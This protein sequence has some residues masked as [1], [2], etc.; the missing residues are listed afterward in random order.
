MVRPIPF[1]SSFQI[2]LLSP[3]L[4]FLPSTPAHAPDP[5]YV[6]SFALTQNKLDVDG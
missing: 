1:L 6:I 2:H 3:G 5:A 4:V